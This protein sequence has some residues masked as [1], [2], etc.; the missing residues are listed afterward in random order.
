VV[1]D[2]AVDALIDAIR[3]GR[4]VLLPTDTVYG[5]VTS[6]DREDYATRVYRLKGR[7][8]TQPSALMAADLDTLFECLPELRG[9]SE[10]IVRE[11]L[12]GPYTLV[13]PNPA[14]RYRW[15]TGNRGESIGVRVPELLPAAQKVLAA[16]GCVMA[17]SANEP[18]GPNPASLDDVPERIRSA[19][20]AE[21]DLGRLPGMPSTVIDFSRAEPY[22]IRDGAAPAADA[23]ERVRAALP[24]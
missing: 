5:L 19:V 9:R 18:G 12:P 17:T 23:I 10:A 8:E 1:G 22:V 24:G 7:P 16:V 11:L 15:L 3:A 14:R 21:L 13:L 2:D 6:A 20:A 4:P